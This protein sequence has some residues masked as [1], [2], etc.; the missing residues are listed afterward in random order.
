VD[1]P[2]LVAEVS[3][4]LAEDRRHRVRG[5]GDAAIGIEAVD[6]FHEPEV[7]HLAEIFERFTSVPVLDG[8]GAGERHMSLDQ[9][10]TCRKVACSGAN[11]QLPHRKSR[12]YAF[13]VS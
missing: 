2:R 11:P 6:R 10:I 1:R 4:E 8:E 12:R 3:F 7:R 9:P 13:P 5:E